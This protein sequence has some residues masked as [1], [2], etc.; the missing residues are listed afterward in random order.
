MKVHHGWDGTALNVKCVTD[1]VDRALVLTTKREG[2]ECDDG[3][4]HCHNSGPARGE[5]PELCTLHMI[6]SCSGHATRS[7]Y[8]QPIIF[9]IAAANY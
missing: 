6:W 2:C 3:Q 8:W 9:P 4:N 5:P 1:P 7:T